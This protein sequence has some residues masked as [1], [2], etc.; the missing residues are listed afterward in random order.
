M[1]LAGGLTA[2]GIE[3][4][5]IGS[6]V[7][8][9][10]W[11]L[12]GGILG[13]L[14]SG[15]RCG[16]ALGSTGDV[17]DVKLRSCAAAGRVKGGQ[18]RA[19][20]AGRAVSRPALFHGEAG[21]A[22][23]AVGGGAGATPAG[24]GGL[25]ASGKAIQRLQALGTRPPLSA[26]TLALHH[27]PSSSSTP[28]SSQPSSSPKGLPPDNFGRLLAPLPRARLGSLPAVANCSPRPPCQS[29]A[30]ARAA[31]GRTLALGASSTFKLVDSGPQ[32]S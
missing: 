32:P 5:G 14:A 16:G 22:R 15:R 9:G 7:G 18:Q 13:Q 26:A 11:G 23:V 25:A 12:V 4:R 30:T 8:G 31:R 20:C 1:A 3:A 2:H 29:A 28:A 19:R 27:T 6:E 24:G 17:C 10:S 21:D